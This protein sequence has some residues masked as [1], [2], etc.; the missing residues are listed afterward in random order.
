MDA[1]RY[2][3]IDRY[4]KKH[5]R[6][7]GVRRELLCACCE[8]AIEDIIANPVESFSERLFSLIKEKGISEVE[9]YKRAGITR[10]VFSKIRSNKDYNPSRNTA[11]SLALSLHLSLKETNK[12]LETAGFALSRSSKADL[13]IEYFIANRNWELSEINEALFS[14]GQDLINV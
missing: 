10:Q 4:I 14:F 13:I 7:Y 12:L 6:V 2:E 8:S 1:E 11:I 9:C 5:L 3:S